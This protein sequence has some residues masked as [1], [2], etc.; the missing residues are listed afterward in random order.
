[1]HTN[2]CCPSPFTTLQVVRKVKGNTGFLFIK[3]LKQQF[4]I[5]LAPFPIILYKF[6]WF[7]V[8]RLLLH[9]SLPSSYE[10]D[11]TIKQGKEAR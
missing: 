4:L 2:R 10:N 1:M 7:K 6:V 9:P 3:M 8:G 5:H 11:N